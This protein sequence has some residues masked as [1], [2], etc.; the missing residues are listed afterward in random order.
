MQSFLYKETDMS[1]KAYEA[2]NDFAVSVMKVNE[3]CQNKNIWDIKKWVLVNKVGFFCSSLAEIR[4]ILLTLS[5][6]TGH[7]LYSTMTLQFPKKSSISECDSSSAGFWMNFKW[8]LLIK[9]KG[10]FKM[11]TAMISWCINDLHRRVYIIIL[12]V[13]HFQSK[14]RGFLHKSIISGHDSRPSTL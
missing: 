5:H 9:Q 10:S 4:L 2:I 13:C 6:Q 8:G 7:T 11:K 12:S 1:Y 14:K 3:S